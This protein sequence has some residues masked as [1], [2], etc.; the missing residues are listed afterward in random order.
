M[1]G[2]FLRPDALLGPFAAPIGGGIAG[3]LMFESLLQL[4][5][6]LVSWGPNVGLQAN[7]GV[8]ESIGYLA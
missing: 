3:Q 7:A 1:Q 4:K 5:A 8:S 2:S 6:L